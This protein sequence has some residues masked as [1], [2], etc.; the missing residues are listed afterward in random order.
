MANRTAAPRTVLKNVICFTYC[1]ILEAFRV[2]KIQIDLWVV[3]G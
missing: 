1:V 2:V 3:V